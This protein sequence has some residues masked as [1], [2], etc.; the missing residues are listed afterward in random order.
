V[1][2]AKAIYDWV[3][4]NAIYDPAIQGCGTGDIRRQFIQRANMVAVQ[5]TSTACL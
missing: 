3:A 2:Q 5:P 4:E 1:A